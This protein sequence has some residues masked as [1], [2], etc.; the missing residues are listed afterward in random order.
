MDIY[1]YLSATQVAELEAL[2]KKLEELKKMRMDPIQLEPS[3][4]TLDP[5]MF[6]HIW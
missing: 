3:S 4:H 5:A 6:T 2:S 1:K